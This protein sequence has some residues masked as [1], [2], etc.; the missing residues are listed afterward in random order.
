MTETTDEF[1]V[2][3][4]LLIGLYITIAVIILI[5]GIYFI[6]Q[7]PFWIGSAFSKGT[8]QYTG[9]VVET[10]YHGLFFK[11]YAVQLKTNGFTPKFEDF[12]ITDKEIYDKLVSMPRNKEITVNYI[13][14]LST[15]S[16]QCKVED[17]SDIVT[18]IRIE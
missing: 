4:G 11:T 16:W 2:I 1:N 10:Q 8:G 18:S 3:K 5:F 7:L 6:M 13:S 12:C 9:T 15:P 14:K 17:S